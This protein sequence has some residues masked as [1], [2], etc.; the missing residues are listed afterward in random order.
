MMDTSAPC[1]RKP[2]TPATF[3]GKLREILNHSEQYDNCAVW[4]SDGMGVDIRDVDKFT[5]KA[6]MECFYHSNFHSFIRQ[7]NL[8]GFRKTRRK[9][10]ERIYKHPN[11]NR[12]DPNLEKFIIRKRRKT[13]TPKREH[14]YHQQN[15]PIYKMYP[16]PLTA[17]ASPQALPRLPSLA[18][19]LSRLNRNNS[20]H[21]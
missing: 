18:V 3:L 2:P 6:L 20:H 21:C 19:V 4:T 5:D 10:S 14:Q 7:L 1:E 13:S 9:L 16:H 8:Y 15:V 11:F 12:F 17:C